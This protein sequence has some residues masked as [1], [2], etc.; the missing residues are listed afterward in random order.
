MKK[1]SRIAIIYNPT[2]DIKKVKLYVE[3]LKAKN[4]EIHLDVFYTDN[5]EDIENKAHAA[6]SKGYDITVAAGGDGTV[7]GVM[8][9]A[10]KHGT[11]FSI[12]PLGTANDFAKSLSIDSVEDAAE[13]LSNG[14][15]KN[16]DAGICTYHADEVEEREMFFCSTAGVGVLARV[17][18]YE[19]YLATKILKGILGNGVWPLLTILS[20]FSSKNTEAELI[21]NERTIKASMRL[22]EISKAPVVGGMHFTPYAGTENGIFDAWLLHGTGSFRS[23]DVFLKADKPGGN[24]FA[25]AGFEYFTHH[26]GFNRYGCS[27][28]TEIAVSPIR[29][30][31]V[32]LNGEKIG[33]TPS[34]FKLLPEAIA[35]VC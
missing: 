25:C 29:P 6:I 18:S 12:L 31:P 27:N 24:H 10:M 32:H 1:F 4:R 11:P 33:Y 22:F 3:L 23:L 30:L 16:V 35:V 15:I 19:K 17:F 21:L 28:L 5:F 8:N 2:K 7:L 14:T 9:A 13:V 20:L 26:G 34:T